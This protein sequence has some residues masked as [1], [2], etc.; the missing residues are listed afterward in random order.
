[1][2]SPRPS[3]KWQTTPKEALRE[4]QSRRL[5]RYLSTVVQPFCPHYR[6][7][8]ERHGFRP[9]KLRR[10]EDL[11]DLPFT[12]KH[13][14]V[15]TPEEPEKTRSFI[16][17]PD[18]AELRKRPSTLLSALCHG[19][20]GARQRLE[21]EFRPMFLT[22]TTGRSAD[23]VPFLYTGHDL[24]RLMLA[25]RRLMEVCGA[26][27]DMRLLNAFPYAPHLGFWQVH[28]AGLALGALMVGSGGG[29]VMGTCGNL[30]LIAKIKPDVLIGVPTFLYHLLTQ[31]VE[32]KAR[33]TCLRKIV[34]GGEK[35]E[36]G[37]RRK[38]R[39]LA[40]R[41][42][43]PAPDVLATYGFTEA[44]LAFAEP[45]FPHEGASSG[46]RTYPDLGI[47]EIIDPDTGR[48]L[49]D[50]TPGEI[51]YTP[52][53]A[54]GTVVVRYRT[55]D[56]IDGGLT[57]EPC[58]FTGSLAPRLV[59]CIHRRSNIKE[60][61]LGKLRGTLVDFNELEH[62]LESTE[63]VGAW[64]IELRKVHDDPLEL[65]EIRLHVEK[66]GRIRE[67]ELSRIIAERFAA[68][69]ELS[70]NRIVFHSASEMRRLQGVGTELKEL[71]ILDN[72]PR[73]DGGVLPRH[74]KNGNGKGWLGRLLGRMLGVAGDEKEAVR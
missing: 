40:V 34:L 73:A 1:M 45:P 32:E 2:F 69:T 38:L 54:R 46:Y 65:D 42:G 64:L 21:H 15:N 41:L 30:R 17:Q 12:D 43:S 20:E 55:G 67:A 37:M 3:R 71:K 35:V 22:S 10:L 27:P 44:K 14:L 70:P 60:M 28:Y 47:V 26:T 72:R 39:E 5:R 25:G 13:D 56:I 7:L 61:Q 19:R 9:E 50:G 51:V 74:G 57:H 11:Q 29:K 4:W 48:V 33:I 59:G 8:F 53:D 63:H 23:P 31:A 68:A 24:D 16:V 52:L 49:P 36:D 66:T 6:G 18:P 58:P 62:V